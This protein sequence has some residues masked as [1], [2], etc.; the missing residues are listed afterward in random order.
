MPALVSNPKVPTLH[1][2]KIRK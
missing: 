1:I 2:Q